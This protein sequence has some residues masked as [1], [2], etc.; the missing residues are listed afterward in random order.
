MLHPAF[1]WPCLV[2]TLLAQA[3][4]VIPTGKTTDEI[5]AAANNVRPSARQFAWQQLGFTAFVH[6]GMNTFTDRESGDGDEQPDTFAPTGLDAEQWATTFADAGMKGL[7][8]TCKH[9]DGFCLWPTGSTT[10]SVAHSKWRDGKGDVVREVAAACRQHGLAFGIYVSPF[11]R[12]NKAFGTGAYQEVFAAQLSELCTSYG[13]L[14]EVWFDRAGCP[15]DDPAVFDWQRMFRI[16]RKLQPLAV[17]AIT[18][19]DVRWV[20]NDAGR[21]RAQEWSVLPLDSDDAA[22]FEDSKNAWQSL[23]RLRA[24]N[25]AA[26]LGSRSALAN[27]RR[28]FWWPAETGVSIRPSWF[29]HPAEDDQVKSLPTLLAFYYAA[30]GG[31]S[32]LL[33][34]VPAN[35]NGRIAEADCAV[36]RDLGA[37]LRATFAK[38]LAADALKKTY[39]F[40]G[41]L[42]FPSARTVSVIELAEDVERAGQ[43]VESFRIDSWDGQQWRQFQAGTTIG[44]RRLLRFPPTKVQGLRYWIEQ[45]RGAAKIKTFAVFRAPDLLVAPTIL[46]DR[47]GSIT[48]GGEGNLRFTTDGSPPSSASPRYEHPFTLARGGIVRAIG[49]PDESK[50][51]TSIGI[52]RAAEACFGITTSKWSLLECSSE[53]APEECANNAF[54]GDPSTIW[55]SRYKP[56][57]EPYPHHLAI[58]LGESVTVT[59]F[60]YLSR[61]SGMNGTI[62]DYSFAVLDAANN[63][64]EVA[65]GTFTKTAAGSPVKVLL[66]EPAKDIHAIRLTALREV[67][68]RA[69]AACAELQLL[70]Q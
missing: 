25:E 34:N 52:P 28:L 35:T 42:Y 14:F 12:N 55:H 68:D 46:R 65:R 54:D 63:W 17:L 44:M 32:Q 6:F 53:Q 66:S 43:C 41:E 39:D 45:S 2:V 47:N 69:F 58:D 13:P 40:A 57:T 59:G 23:T 36:L 7:V 22:A 38:D 31:N 18:G 70:V 19:P 60:R 56:W 1:A 51:R 48:I 61:P 10:H 37:C 11:D 21:T 49:L 3:P 27:A 62:A 67:D 15:V 16:V 24:R 26:D 4:V 20:G 8:L 33:L 5:A 30:V 9:H 64:R 50:D 29:F